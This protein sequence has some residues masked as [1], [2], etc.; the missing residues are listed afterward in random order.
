ME[1]RPKTMAINTLH[2]LQ[3]EWRHRSIFPKHLQQAFTFSLVKNED[4]NIPI[5]PYQ[6]TD[7]TPHLT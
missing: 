5:F 1:N 7:L 6:R 2:L 4:T 3:L